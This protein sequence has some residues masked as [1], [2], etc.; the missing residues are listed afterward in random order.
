MF[1]ELCRNGYKLQIG[2]NSAPT[3]N[4]A[5]SMTLIISIFRLPFCLV[6]GGVRILCVSKC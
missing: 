2:I 3:D 5:V 6:R 1:G 4:N